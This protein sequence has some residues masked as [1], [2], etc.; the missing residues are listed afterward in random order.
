M[1]KIEKLC[2]YC[3]FCLFLGLTSSSFSY[4]IENTVTVLQSSSQKEGPNGD[5]KKQLKKKYL[6]PNACCPYQPQV[7]TV[8]PY[9]FY[10]PYEFDYYYPQTN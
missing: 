3:V 8:K 7:E 5:N 2:W 9:S 4:I 10:Y 1:K 6:D